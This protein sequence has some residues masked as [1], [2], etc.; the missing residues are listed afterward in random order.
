[1]TAQELIDTIVMHYNGA[2][3]EEAVSMGHWSKPQ[4]S[5]PLTHFC[6]QIVVTLF[7]LRAMASPRPS[8]HPESWRG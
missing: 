4:W 5:A 2:P 1:M 6:P 8:P 3:D 7:E